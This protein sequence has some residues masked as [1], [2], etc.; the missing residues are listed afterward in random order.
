MT[1]VIQMEQTTSTTEAT[2]YTEFK[3]FIEGVSEFIYGRI[4][5]SFDEEKDYPFYWTVNHYYTPSPSA[6]GNYSPSAR[7][8]RT[9]EEAYESMMVYLSGATSPLTPN[10]HY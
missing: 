1:K 9:Q 6:A 5:E 4:Q 10:E 8:F 2:E 7:D 3:F